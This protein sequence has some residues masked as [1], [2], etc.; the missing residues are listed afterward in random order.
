MQEPKLSCLEAGFVNGKFKIDNTARIQEW[1]ERN[2]N[3]INAMLRTPAGKQTKCFRVGA[4]VHCTE[5]G[6]IH[7]DVN[8][9]IEEA[10]K[11]N[12]FWYYIGGGMVHRASD[13]TTDSI[14]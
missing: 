2:E 11:Q 1:C 14:K 3:E 4:L 8:F 10:Y 5:T 6:G 13:I 9:R 12:G 7:S